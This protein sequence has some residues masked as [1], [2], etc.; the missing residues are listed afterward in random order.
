MSEQLLIEEKIKNHFPNAERGNFLQD[1]FLEQLEQ[2]Y[3]VRLGETMLC[4]SHCPDDLNAVV[5]RTLNE[6]TWN[7]NDRIWGPFLLGGLGGFPFGGK[8]GMIAFAEQVPE[9]HTALI[10]YGPHVGINQEGQLGRLRRHQHNEDSDSC[11]ALMNVLQ[12]F[13]EDTY[14]EPEPDEAD[15]QQQYLEKLLL[16]HR[17]QILASDD[18]TREITECAF[19]IIE[20]NIVQLLKSAEHAFTCE[21]I[22]LVGMISVNTAPELQDYVDIRTSIV[23]ERSFIAS[24]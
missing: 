9:G 15:F 7:L 5:S 23:I 14:C 16:P 1:T 2:A 11:R 13:R 17:E 20:S 18:P 3:G 6:S 22:A 10:L 19:K 12:R 4:S 21:Q 8:S 24:M